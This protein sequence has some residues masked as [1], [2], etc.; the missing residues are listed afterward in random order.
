MA[1]MNTTYGAGNVTTQTSGSPYPG[2]DNTAL[3]SFARR[4]AMRRRRQEEEPT[5][6]RVVYEPPAQENQE[7]YADRL[8]RKRF[9]AAALAKAEAGNQQAPQKF[10]HPSYGLGGYM[11]D[12]QAMTGNQRE[13]FLP[14]GA[15]M[16]A[17]GDV[18]SAGADLDEAERRRR[19]LAAAAA[20]QDTR[21]DFYGMIGR[22]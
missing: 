21:P 1:N 9:E 5:P 2:I 12:T 16:S 15:S 3:L 7:N 22:A 6:S 18:P 13:I 17:P 10:F 19:L 20:G 11:D 4:M 8:T 14:Q